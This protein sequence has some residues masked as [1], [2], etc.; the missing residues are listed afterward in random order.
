MIKKL[1]SAAIGLV[2][3][4][5]YFSFPADAVEPIP[6]ISAQYA[7]VVE[8]RSGRILAGYRENERASMASTTKIMT[9]LLLCENCDLDQTAVV[10]EKMV[11][12]EGSS[13]GLLPGDTV[14]YRDL[15]YGMMLAS[16]NDAATATAILIAGS[17]EAFATM[18]NER[19]A[20]IG[21]KNTHFVT[22]SGLDDEEHYSTAYDMALL[23]V[24]ALKNS[25][26]AQAAA[27]RTAC[28]EYGNPPYK[29]TL[30]NH[31]KL[32]AYFP[33]C[34]GIKTGFTKKSGRCLVS[35]A[36]R[37][38]A[39]VVVVTLN[40]PNDWKDHETLLEYGLRQLE[41]CEL[42][43]PELPKISVVGGKSADLS[44]RADRVTVAL[45][46]EDF[47]KVTVSVELSPSVFAPIQEGETVGTVTYRLNGVI[48]AQSDIT[49]AQTVENNSAMKVKDYRYWLRL[50]LGTK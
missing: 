9:A 49:A 25:D 45:V 4:F 8:R 13:M 7:V 43:S 2:L 41:S 34:D 38:N 1:L 23:A 44:V 48:L 28:L 42:D 5:S 30:T 33:D 18:M 46:P 47:E 17:T 16:G 22:P 15:L 35:S 3:I 27:S 11:N 19:A 26:F 6:A 32:L 20:Q 36:S 39:G 10:T 12:V 24:E 40:D 31:N 21:M 50:L 29:R 14:H 37:D